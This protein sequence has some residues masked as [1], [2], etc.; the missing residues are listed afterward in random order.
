[1]DEPRTLWPTAIWSQLRLWE[2]TVGIAR[3]HATHSFVPTSNGITVPKVAIPQN[4]PSRSSYWL[5]ILP[6][7]TKSISIWTVTRINL[8]FPSRTLVP[9]ITKE[10]N[11]PKANKGFIVNNVASGIQAAEVAVGR[12][13]NVR[14]CFIQSTLWPLGKRGEGLGGFHKWRSHSRCST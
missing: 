5:P 7:R 12:R 10:R 3:Q 8:I 11:E 4:C 2:T 14:R 6:T 13:S 9:L 1:M